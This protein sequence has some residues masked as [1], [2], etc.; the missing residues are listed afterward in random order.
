MTAFR[1]PP[2]CL[3]Q[4]TVVRQIRRSAERATKP[5]AVAVPFSGAF[6][7]GRE[8]A[9]L[10]RPALPT[11]APGQTVG[12]ALQAINRRLDMPG[13]RWGRLTPWLTAPLD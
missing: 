12:D 11:A 7:T 13:Y 8:I 9:A 1:D 6:P 4:P 3:L 10:A 2:V 5:V